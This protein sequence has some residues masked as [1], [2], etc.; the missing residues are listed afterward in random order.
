MT[1]EEAGALVLRLQD[2]DILPLSFAAFCG[3]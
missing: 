1:P 3:C 2:D